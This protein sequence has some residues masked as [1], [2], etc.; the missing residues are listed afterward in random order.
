L[1]WVDLFE[2][3]GFEYLT[4]A[5]DYE[6]RQRQAR[7]EPKPVTT[8]PPTDKPLTQSKEPEPVVKTPTAKPNLRE[9]YEQQKP[10][11]FSKTPALDDE[12]EKR[13]ATPEPEPAP[14]VKPPPSRPPEIKQ[15]PT[16]D[17]ITKTSPNLIQKLLKLSRDP[18]WQ[19]IGVMV[20]I[21]GV[22]WAIYTFN[23][24]GN[25]SGT[26]TIT[27]N[28]LAAIVASSPTNT[29]TAT[30][31]P[32]ATNTRVPP[33][34]TSVPPTDTPL[35]T[36]VVLPTY[37]PITGSL[38]QTK[39]STDG[40]PQVLVPAGP[41][42]MGSDNGE[43]DEAPAHTVTLDAFYIDQYEVTN[44]RYKSCVNA[45]ECQE[46]GCSDRYGNPDKKNH[47][48]VCVTW[49]QAR[50]Y[51]EWRGDRLPTEA[52]WEKAARGTDERTYPW[53]ENINC[54]LANYKSSCVGDTTPGGSYV[55][56]VSPYGVY[57]LAGNV[58]EWVQSVYQAYPYDPV[59]GRENL[60][61]TNVRVLRGGGW[62]S[63]ELLARAS[64][65]DLDRPGTGDDDL[66]FRCVASAPE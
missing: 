47:P 46:P 33:T 4:R 18:I 48:V 21:I 13:Q 30:N 56:G 41:F 26:P 25:D 11:T 8:P 3:E 39:T 62:R 54:E 53:G 31:T 63:S 34:N 28:R 32:P 22:A 61:S 50:T 5:L 60:D 12:I 20:G 1:H 40:A 16:S 57:D 37:T 2:L 51:C 42:T 45:G 64:Y 6:L 29:P 35:P 10:T 7:V 44:A 52:E 27:P 9:D 49:S 17:E 59:D 43:V 36:P 55:N 19:T 23:A 24:G 15:P 14:P 66:G 65:R 38:P 58:W